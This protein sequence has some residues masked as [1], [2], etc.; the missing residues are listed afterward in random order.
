MA[1]LITIQEYYDWIGLTSPYDSDDE[2]QIEKMITWGSNWLLKKLG[3]NF[4]DSA[5]PIESVEIFSGNGKSRYFTL[6]AP[7][8]SVSTIEYWD[9]S[10]WTEIDLTQQLYTNNENYIY[11][12]DG[13]TFFKPGLLNLNNWRVTYYYGGTGIPTDIKMAL[14][15]FV[16][17]QITVTERMGDVVLQQDGE[18][19]FQYG[20]RKSEI[21][22]EKTFSGI[23]NEYKR[24]SSGF[25]VS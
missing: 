17:G 15:M 16:S 2:T 22:A 7:I 19:K 5:S 8:S 11:F 3:R 12:Q 20:S 23:I 9:G 13:N 10:V 6:E 1:D 24:Y 4:T 25:K 18:Q 21:T 14:C